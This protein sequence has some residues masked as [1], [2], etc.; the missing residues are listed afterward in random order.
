MI[1]L[2]GDN[3]IQS[4]LALT[5]LKEKALK[6]GEEVVVVNGQKA[7]LSEVKQALESGSLFG[8]DRLLVI[9]NLLVGKVS[10]SQKEIC[11]Y[12]KKAGGNAVIWESK[13][14]SLT[15]IKAV[16]GEAREFKINPEIFNLTDSLSPNN[17][18]AML[19]S[20]EVCL[21]QED[22]EMIFY[23]L[24]RQVRMMIQAK[25]DRN[26]VSGSPYMI[27][28]LMAQVKNFEQEQLLKMHEKLY[29]IDKGVKTGTNPL[30]LSDRLEQWL[31]E[32]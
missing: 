14:V 24:C 26:S 9:E 4:R 7:P 20:L 19:E 6:R 10:K 12:L 28:K 22:A 5:E 2:H 3:Q 27:S 15:A 23:M 21:Q 18:K 11:E 1:V 30:P 32:I 17:T 13:K 31:L 25:T 8:G 29:D 16:N